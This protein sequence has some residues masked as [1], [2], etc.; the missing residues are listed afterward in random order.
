[1]TQQQISDNSPGS[2]LF[3]EYTTIYDLIAQE[4]EGL[5][6]EQLDWT[7]DQWGWAEWS[8]RRQ[9]S[10]MASLLYRWMVV[11]WADV[12]FPDGDHGVGDVEGVAQSSYDR[13][14]DKDKYREMPVILDALKEGI[15]LV[16]RVMDSHSVGFLREN[17]IPFAYNAQWELMTKAHPS[18]L[19]PPS[20]GETEATFNLEATLRHMYFEETTHLYNIQR[21]KRA[22][23]LPTVVDVPDVGYWIVEG[24]DRSEP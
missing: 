4:V 21:L 13:A 5:T 14:M 20:G 12:L 3:P 19:I 10:H 6:D 22:Q 7:S 2:A 1:M 8:I 24:W 11:R 23:G 17:S 9:V 18:G 15:A 16:Q